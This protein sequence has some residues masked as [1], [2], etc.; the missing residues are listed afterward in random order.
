MSHLVIKHQQSETNNVS[1]F[2]IT[3]PCR[4]PE[5]AEGEHECQEIIDVEHK[6]RRVRVDK[7]V[8][9]HRELKRQLAARRQQS[10][11]LRHQ[12][13]VRRQQAAELYRKGYR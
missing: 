2:C 4:C 8:Q 1:Q 12:Q 10:A 13:L 9:F 6:R 7:D 3:M 5:A 11:S